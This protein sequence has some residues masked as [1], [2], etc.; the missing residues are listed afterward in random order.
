ML[1]FGGK[2]SSVIYLSVALWGLTFGGAATL[3]QTASADAAGD[4][5]DVAQSMV[6]TAWNLTIAGG[7]I[8]GEYY[9]KPAGY[10][11]SLGL[12]VFCC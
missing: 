8:I 4:G 7:G 12:Y 1:G 6:V 11:H 2:V 3:L 9:W 10:P 5:A